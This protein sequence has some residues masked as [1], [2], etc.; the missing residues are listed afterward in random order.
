MNE[1]EKE[2]LQAVVDGKR[3]QGLDRNSEWSEVDDYCAL[4]ILCSNRDRGCIIELRVKPETML[5]NGVEVPAA[6][7]EAPS[8]GTKFWFPTYW[9]ESGFWHSYWMPQGNQALALKR[10]FVHLSEEN[11]IAHAKALGWYKE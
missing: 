2:I 3:I 4:Q 9:K 6:E 7:T 5:V 11:C 1:Y 10:G 8:Y